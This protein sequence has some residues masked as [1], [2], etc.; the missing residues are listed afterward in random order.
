MRDIQAYIDAVERSGLGDDDV[1]GD[2]GGGRKG[3][4]GSAAEEFRTD[5]GKTPNWALGL[6][7]SVV[8]GYLPVV[9]GKRL[10]R[11]GGDMRSRRSGDREVDALEKG[12]IID[13]E[14]VAFPLI[15][16]VPIE[17]SEL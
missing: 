16:W 2:R 7:A 17:W 14:G 8:R 11:R 6:T 13:L 15:G 9:G 3:E 12:I 5:G 10:E 4:T 1:V